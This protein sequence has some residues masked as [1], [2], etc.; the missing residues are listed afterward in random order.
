MDRRMHRVRR[1][2][3]AAA[4]SAGVVG[5]WSAAAHAQGAA[6]GSSSGSSASGSEVVGETVTANAIGAQF[7]FNIPGL[8]PLPNQN[9]IEEDAP[10][11]RSLVSTGP[12][13]QSIGAPYYP[14]DILANLGGLESEF[15][16]PSFPNIPYPFMAEAEYPATPQY[17]ASATFGGPPPGGSSPVSLLSG[18]AHAT[19]S[20]GDANGTLTDLSVGAGMGQGGAPLLEAAS[21]Q[22]NES[23]SIGASQVTATARSVIKSIEIAGMVDITEL[24][25]NAESTSDGTTGTP[26]ATIDIGQVTV[27]GQPAYIDNQGVHVVGTNPAPAGTPTVA[28]LQYSLDQTL[29][30][31]GITIRL[32]DP[33]QTSN[34]AEGIANSGGLVVSISHNFS[35][36]FVNLGALTG[37]A[38]QPCI[39]TQDITQALGQGGGLGSVCLPAGNYTA[40]T[41]ITLGFAT[42][43]VNASA[44]QSLGVPSVNLGPTGPGP[45]G[46]GLL[47][48]TTGTGLTALGN[49]TSLGTVS[50][51]GAPPA[52]SSPGGGLFRLTLHGIPNPVGWVVGGILLCILAAYPMMLVARWQFLV[53]RR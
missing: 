40:V 15:F 49:Q 28:Q 47:P 12:T 21:E 3:A 18:S 36:P 32:V 43:D 26:N 11:A 17:G 5:G 53:G 31:D 1:L 4:L 9:L 46:L 30:Q 23:V 22:S 41:S 34:G 7:A 10:F 48:G 50:G 20:G 39:P 8:V 38:L 2:L 6:G 19:D 33:E 42:T 51:P 25:S 24:T 13:V 27:D 29:A 45:T 14:G 44:L 16:P 35:V 37:N 52:T